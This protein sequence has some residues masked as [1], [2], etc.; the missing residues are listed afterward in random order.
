MKNFESH[1]LAL[2]IIIS[3]SLVVTLFLGAFQGYTYFA[4][5]NQLVEELNKLGDLQVERLAYDLDSPMWELDETSIKKVLQSGLLNEQVHAIYVTGD[6]NVSVSVS[7]GNALHN[8]QVEEDHLYRSQSI[9]HNGRKIGVVKLDLTNEF[10][11]KRLDRALMNALVLSSLEIVIIILLLSIMLRRII[12]RPIGL[13]V[14][15]TRRIAVGD[16]ENEQL[17]LNDDEIGSLGESIQQM[18][19]KIELREKELKLSSA[20]LKSIKE[21]LEYAVNGSRDGLWDWN[22]ET[23]EVYFSPRWKEMLGYK[24]DELPNLFESW[25]NNVHP[26][27]LE[28]AKRDISY[29][30]QMPGR[31]Y[32]LVHRLRHKNGS[33]VW[34]LS[35]AQT[36]FNEEGKAIRMVGFHTDITKQKNLEQELMDHREHLEVLIQ[37]RTIELNRQKT[38][39]QVVLENISDGIVACDEKGTL[40]LFNRAAKQMHGIEFQNLPSDQWA[41]YYDLY[42]ADGLTPMKTE[43]TPIFRTFQGE[44]LRNEEMAIAPKNGKK[45][46]VISSGQP[47][48]DENGS[49]IGAVVSLHDVSDQRQSEAL[50]QAAKDAAESA[51]QAK[52]QFLANMSHEIRTPINAIMG[53]QYL[54]EKTE[55]TPQ[56]INYI[57][58][59]QSAAASLLSVIN[60]I[61]DFSKIEA[62]KLDLETV[63]FQLDK[64]LEDF[65]DVIGY[66]ANDSG[67]KLSITRDPNIPMLLRGDPNRLRQV[68]INLG[69]NAVKFT[70][71]GSVDV[72]VHCLVCDDK[73]ARLEFS[74][75]DSGIGMTP[76][77]QA[78]L[79]QEFSQADTSMTRRFGG[80]GLGLVI[81]QKLAGMMGG[82]V[83]V[84]SSEPGIG[85]TF[86][87]SV[88]FETAGSEQTL[89]YTKAQGMEGVLSKISVLIVDDNKSDR[90]VLMSTAESLGL[91]CEA[92][93][94]GAK[95]VSALEQ[96]VYDV[97][98]MDWKMPE[99]D[100]IETANIIRN[101]QS[102]KKVPKIIMVTAYG[103]EDVIET[104]KEAELDGL[105][106]KP[107]SPSMMLN[108]IVQTKG[109]QAM[110]DAQPEKVILTLAPIKGA[111]VLLVEDNEIN[112]EFAQEMLRGEGIVVDSANDGLEAI[113]KA[114]ESHYDMI[115]MDIQMPNLD[116]LEATKRIR[117]LKD[118]LSDDYYANVP[119]VA[120][121]ANALRSDID[122]SLKAGMNAYIVK[123]IHP[124]LLFETMLKW[125]KHKQ[126]VPSETTPSIK[127]QELDM[128]Y[129]FSKLHGIDIEDALMRTM[130]KKKL[131]VKLLGQF[132]AKYRD[133]F[134]KVQKLIAQNNLVEAEAQC[135]KL[136]GVIGTLGAV[137]IFKALQEIDTTLKA[138]KVPPM[139]NIERVQ[140]MFDSLFVSIGDFLVDN[141]QRS[142]KKAVT[143]ETSAVDLKE[144]LE[145]VI[146][147]LES[148]ISISLDKFD[149]FKSV[150]GNLVDKAAVERMQD[151]LGE[152]DTDTA[153]EEAQLMLQKLDNGDRE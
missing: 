57:D 103:R 120:L 37:A 56:Q 113:K 30:Q 89:Q 125:I 145:S 139:Q 11:E 100:G 102:V 4:L 127:S 12:L 151:A 20:Q 47:L 10:M 122:I 43:D 121:S 58:K 69:N 142:D 144:L 63:T 48:F 123:P 99:M 21:Q 133:S 36:I 81:S 106:L 73:V 44:E 19:E 40:S 33:W 39:V 149:E 83:W 71:S 54:L 92:V 114:K 94:S 132:H 76:E 26:D 128:E 115:L 59:S 134:E 49:K 117:K 15:S 131:F 35:R 146:E 88:L 79:F 1:S 126:T 116:G 18:R 110:L 143:T 55:L 7:R 98:L 8:Y 70:Q 105:L 3:V 52:S 46:Q 23:N 75:Q 140:N 41:E 64:V 67:L 135:H 152:F 34:I 51:N 45:L 119:I 148:D 22:I 2:K 82:K 84:K 87:F 16:Y 62:G 28:K 147:Y 5:N 50:M 90:E 118:I 13:L 91:R 150:C 141:S 77:Q 66:K 65:N 124:E 112:R 68:L 109:M 130:Q 31:L 97:L 17:K 72:T 32:E 137:E 129:D 136:K 96:K 27:D 6:E 95:A 78:N 25:E 74:I 80:T 42:L 14:E 9:F 61:L 104:I 86:C 38:F 107:V 138:S 93:A 60:D 29:S 153:K 24:N 111:K 101:S 108:V 85:S 53:M